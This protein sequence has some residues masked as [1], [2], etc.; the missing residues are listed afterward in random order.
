MKEKRISKKQAY[1]LISENVKGVLNEL[2]ASPATQFGHEMGKQAGRKLG[3]FGRGMWIDSALSQ[4]LKCL[5]N[6]RNTNVLVMD[7]RAAQSVNQC[8]AV[9][10]KLKKN[11]M[12]YKRS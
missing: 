11:P 10:E 5:T 9:L 8:I 7:S 4:A 1:D 12:R 3:F 6:L 2:L